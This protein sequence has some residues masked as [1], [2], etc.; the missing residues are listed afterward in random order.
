MLT[1][2]LVL[3]VHVDTRVIK[4]RDVDVGGLLVSSFILTLSLDRFI[5]LG[6][7]SWATILTII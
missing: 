1:F 5:R 3:V 7:L 4:S 2:L 6:C